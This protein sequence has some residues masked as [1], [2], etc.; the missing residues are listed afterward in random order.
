[1]KKNERRELG[2]SLGRSCLCDGSVI[3]DYTVEFLAAGGM[4]VAYKGVRDGKTYVLKE[5]EVQNTVNVPALMSEKG[6]LERL[7]HPGIVGY[8]GLLTVE[9][10]YYLVVEYV[11]GEP[12]SRWL[13]GDE[14]APVDSIVEWGVQLCEIFNYLHTRQPVIIYRDLKPENVLLSGDKVKLIDFG[15]A[16]LHKGDQRTEDTTLLGSPAT[17][18][19]EHYGQAETDARSDIFTLGATLYQLLLGPSEGRSGA[20]KFTPPHELR[21]EVPEALSQAILKALSVD[22]DE[23]QQTALEFRDEL[24]LAMGRPLPEKPA[25]ETPEEPD[26]ET[27]PLPDESSKP[28]R[29][30]LLVAVVLLALV[31]AVAVPRLF[32][33]PA[34]QEAQ[35]KQVMEEENLDGEVFF[36][37]KVDQTDVLMLGEDVGLFQVTEWEKQSGEERAQTL[38]KRMNGFYHQ[39]CPLCSKSKLE[40][41]DIRVGRHIESKEVAVFYAHQH[42]D[43]KVYAGPILL[44][45]VTRPQAQTLNSTPRFVAATWRDLLRDTVELSRGHAVHDSVL[46]EEMEQALLRA[47]K[48]LK[49]GEVSTGNLLRVLRS[50]RPQEALKLQRIFEQIPQESSRSDQFEKIKGYE[51]LKT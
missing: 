29:R 46:G 51:P 34:A 22:A 7:S 30:W 25:P 45:T 15:I 31:G 44:A 47:R 35:A 5:V 8:H 33:S 41:Q 49:Q 36:A 9:G 3:G 13:K 26:R 10:H 39:F 17:A 24:L 16:R 43:L 23:R 19:P 27:L 11:E 37:S 6:L 1:M 28:N 21:P 50:I 38:A 18:S 4:S 2:D 48:E 40:P 42:S 32:P 14:R 12:L 20:F